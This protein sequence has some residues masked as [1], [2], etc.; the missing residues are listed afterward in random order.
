MFHRAIDNTT[1]NS[2]HEV[3]FFI[4]VIGPVSAFYRLLRFDVYI[5]MELSQMVTYG[6]LL[7]SAVTCVLR[8]ILSSSKADIVNIG[9]IRQHVKEQCSLTF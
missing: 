7:H 3:R 4:Y 8:F 9:D 5:N 6:L 2:E 1:L